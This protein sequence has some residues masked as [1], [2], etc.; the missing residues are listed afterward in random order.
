MTVEIAVYVPLV[1]PARLFLMIN[2]AN[3]IDVNALLSSSTKRVHYKLLA[4]L[5]WR[6]PPLKFGPRKL[7]LFSSSS[8]IFLSNQ[9]NVADRFCKKRGEQLFAEF[10][11]GTATADCMQSSIYKSFSSAAI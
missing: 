4:S 11:G 9:I 10:G 5:L 1:C 3:T 2:S 6:S 8:G 7:R